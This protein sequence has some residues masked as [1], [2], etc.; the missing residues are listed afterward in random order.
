M[1]ARSGCELLVLAVD[2]GL[3]LVLLAALD[4]AD[5]MLV[6][7]WRRLHGHQSLY[8]FHPLLPVQLEHVHAPYVFIP[9]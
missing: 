7:V 8:G 9:E 5:W 2:L 1:V 6:L 4:S 3:G